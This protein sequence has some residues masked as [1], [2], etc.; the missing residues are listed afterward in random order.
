MLPPLDEADQIEDHFHTTLKVV[1]G[2]SPALQAKAFRNA[3]LPQDHNNE[4]ASAMLERI[5][6]DRRE[7]SANLRREGASIASSIWAR[8]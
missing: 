1:D 3:L 8:S 5:R 2:L 6:T 7:A 4:P